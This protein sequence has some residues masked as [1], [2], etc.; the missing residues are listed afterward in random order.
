MAK[1]K[2]NKAK[3]SGAGAGATMGMK[4]SKTQT[5]TINKNFGKNLRGVGG[6]V[7]KPTQVL[8]QTKKGK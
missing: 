3:V 5:P 1:S 2:P 7:W 6:S 8:N 4:G